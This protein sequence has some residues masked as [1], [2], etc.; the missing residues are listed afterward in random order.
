L[1]TTSAIGKTKS[2]GG[3]VSALVALLLVAGCF[4]GGAEQRQGASQEQTQEQTQEQ[5]GPPVTGNF[6]GKAPDEDAFVAIVAASPD[7][8]EG[9]E[10]DV[11]A[12]L[13][14]GKRISEW[15]TGR[16][17]A[18]ELNLISEGGARLEGNLSPEAST[19]TITLKDD[20][21]ITYTADLATGIA[22]LYNVK[23]SDEGRVRG[24]SETGVILEGEIGEEPLEE[25][26]E[27][28]GA[29]LITG[30][31]TSPDGQAQDFR[32]LSA[33]GPTENEYRYVVLE[34]GQIRGARKGRSTGSYLDAVTN[35]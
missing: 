9:Q 27:K 11:R 30:T 17:D 26:E 21:T 15:F 23:V 10:R 1:T 22:G 18:N 13:C 20:R 14:D 8:E 12:Y 3:F 4:G 7:E 35:Y 32:V 29:Y 31:I 34:D 28:E 5:S 6:V 2:V 24:T 25:P 19:G 16:A 33:S